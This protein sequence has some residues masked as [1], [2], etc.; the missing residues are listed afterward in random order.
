LLLFS[1]LRSHL[2]STLFPYTT[3]F[4][5]GLVPGRVVRAEHGLH[6]VV[7]ETGSVRAAVTSDRP[8]PC[9]GDWVVVQPVDAATSATVVEVL[10]C[11]TAV[12]RSISL[13]TLQGQVLA[14]DV[15]IVDVIVSPF[16]PLVLRWFK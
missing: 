2:S 9:T 7:A 11:R 14:A 1:H 5:S 13:R 15:L 16:C 3:L 6:D 4:R 10:E 12:D 8:T